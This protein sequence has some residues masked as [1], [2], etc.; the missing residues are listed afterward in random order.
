MNLKQILE[1][2]DKKHEE[3]RVYQKISSIKQ[4][5][6]EEILSI[7]SEIYKKYQ[8]QLRQEKNKLFLRNTCSHELLLKY[9]TG[10]EPYD[11]EK[12]YCICCGQEFDAYNCNEQKASQAIKLLK[13][14]Y[15]Y[16]ESFQELITDIDSYIGG[17]YLQNPE[18]DIDELRS[19]IKEFIPLRTEKNRR[20]V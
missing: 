13:H 19:Y 15:D 5:R 10:P 2:T 3:E 18:M 4:Q 1:M 16:D 8:E 11:T 17:L 20:R 7:T 9:D 14:Y 6:D 12:Y